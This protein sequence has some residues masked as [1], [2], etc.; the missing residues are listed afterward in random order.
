M[1]VNI[2]DKT[3]VD[4]VVKLI[5][6]SGYDIVP[7]K[8]KLSASEYDLTKRDLEIIAYIVENK[9]SMA[10]IDRLINTVKSC[11]Y[12]A[13]NGIEGAFVEC[14]VWRG[15]NAIAA[16]MV[17]EDLSDTR[18]CWLFDT[19]EG[20][21]P[22][23][24]IDFDVSTG[25]PAETDY[26][27]LSNTSEGWCFASL[28]EV[29]R[30][31]EQ[32]GVSAEQFRLVKGDV[33]KTLTDT[34]NLPASISVLRLDTDWYAST[35]RELEVLYPRVGLGGILILDDYGKWHGAK[36]AVHEYFETLAFK[37]MLNRIDKS[38]RFCIKIK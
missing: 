16:K 27:R 23:E 30:N 6:R 5:K 10:S 19:F 31:I 24:D 21:P 9:L 35:K 8:T 26:Q 2:L 4:T 33:C 22:P 34:E 11:R 1:G 17:F 20:M 14:G 7:S 37:P 13:E 3:L 36:S 15:G 38:G 12:V 28:S 29:Q 32:S 25:A 18:E